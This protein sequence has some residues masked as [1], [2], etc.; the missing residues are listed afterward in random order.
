MTIMILEIEA[1]DD[2]ID[3]DGQSPVDVQTVDTRLESGGPAGGPGLGRKNKK[4][5]PTK[6][7][8]FSLYCAY[9]CSCR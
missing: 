4:I 5:N 6:L 3:Q 2:D 8:C 9:S 1:E 7:I